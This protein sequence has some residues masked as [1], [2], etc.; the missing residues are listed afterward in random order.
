MSITY[1]TVTRDIGGTNYD[2]DVLIDGNNGTAEQ[3]YEF[4]QRELRKSTDIDDG[5]GTVIGELADSLLEFV[6]DTLKTKNAFIDNFQAN[7]TNRIVFEDNT[8]AEVTFPFVAAGSLNFNNNLQNDSEAVYRMFFSS[9]FGSPSAIIV[10]DNSGTP[11]SGD[12]NGAA[13]VSFDF[14]YDGNNQGGRTPGTDAAITV[15][16]I[17][18]GTAQ[19]VLAEGVITRAVGQGISLVST[20]ERNYSNP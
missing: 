13:S 12:V 7:D 17:G 4:V 15:V 10:Q 9:G 18:E 2:F 6:G 14:D 5:A 16:A 20:L 11:I 19:Y 1:G 3:I 8:G